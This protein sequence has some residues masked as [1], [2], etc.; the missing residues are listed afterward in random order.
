M[1]QADEHVIERDELLRIVDEASEGLTPSTREKYA[2]VA[3]TTEAVTV[4]RFHCDGVG[5]P[6]RQA[7]R[8]N[9]RFQ[10]AFDLAM[11]ARFGIYPEDTPFVVRV[12]P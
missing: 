4:G 3:R 12:L 7:R 2:A 11:G 1:T 10:E 6:A 8:H 5:C 9:Q